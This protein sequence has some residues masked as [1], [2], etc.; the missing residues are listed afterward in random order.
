MILLLGLALSAHAEDGGSARHHVA[1]A[2]QFVKNKWYADA[3]TEVEAALAAAGGGESFDAHWIGA[4]VYLELMDI[5]RATALADRAA[6]LAPDADARERAADYAVFLRQSFGV[7]ELSGPDDGLRSRLQVESDSV[8][9]DAELKRLAGKVALRAREGVTLPVR[10]SLPAGEWRING[11]AVKVPAGGLA[12][13]RLDAKQLGARGLASLR[14]TR[15]ELSAGTS[16]H[17]GARVANLGVGGALELGLDVPA[18]PLFLGAVAAWDLRSYEAAGGARVTDPRALGGG[19]RVGVEVPVG[20]ALALR[21]AIGA[22]FGLVP[23]IAFDCT[24][25]EGALVCSIPQ[26]DE[27][28]RIF[29]LGR[30][31]TPFVELGVEHRAKGRATAPGLGLKAVVEQQFGWVPD[32]GSAAVHASDEVLPYTVDDPAWSAT[33][34]RL[35]ASFSLAF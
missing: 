20:G 13:L 11:A 24:D 16:A 8:I 22:R 3:A 1:Q 34:V 32:P 33:G 27:G 30:A 12:R 17:F 19:G 25:A 28:T 14:R 23:G 10:L 29:A 21:P 31:I 5:A 6:A 9:F 18:G 26:G 7:V 35:L 4:Q 15:V 2:R